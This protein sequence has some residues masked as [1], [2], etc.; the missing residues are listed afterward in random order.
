MVRLV[1]TDFKTKAASEAFYLNDRTDVSQKLF[2]YH[3]FKQYW[4]YMSHYRDNRK[5]YSLNFLSKKYLQKNEFL[6]YI[7]DEE[8]VILFN[9]KTIYASKIN[10][11]FITDD[12]IKSIL[13]TRHFAML[14]NISSSEKRLSYIVDSRYKLAIE[15]ILKENTKIED[16]VIAYSMGDIDDLTSTMNELINTKTHFSRLSFVVIF[17]IGILWSMFYGLEI[18]SNKVF[19]NTSL[20]DLRTEVDFENRAVMR[21]QTILD[22]NTLQYNELTKCLTHPTTKVNQ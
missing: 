14:L 18:F 17:T 8:Y 22:K 4:V 1:A 20:D 10:I 19:F 3:Y 15:N 13:L 21:Q 11:N 16:R 2:S 12:I 6:L 7:T 9:H 5:I